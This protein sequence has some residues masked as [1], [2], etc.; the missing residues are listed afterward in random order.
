MA[1]VDAYV[2]VEVV[3]ALPD[4]QHL[5]SI[6]LQPGSTIRDAVMRSGIARLHP[7]IDPETCK[8]GIFGKR[9]ALETVLRDGDRVEIY[10]PL[11]ADPKDARRSRV[12]R[13]LP[14]GERA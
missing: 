8:A 9:Q 1:L 7:E 12:R 3:Y 5:L 11:T 2:T 13:R 10:R 6:T 4:R 14:A